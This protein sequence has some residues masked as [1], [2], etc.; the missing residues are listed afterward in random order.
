MGRQRTRRD[1]RQR[2]GSSIDPSCLDVYRRHG[3]TACK[4][5]PAIRQN[6]VAN[7]ASAQ[8]DSIPPLCLLSCALSTAKS[9]TSS[10]SF[11][12]RAAN[13]QR[14]NGDVCVL[15]AGLTAV[16]YGV[17]MALTKKIAID[18]AVSLLRS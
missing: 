14:R 4:A 16:G 3:P 1:P 12:G 10:A 2:A 8:D 18:N 6:G 17:L 13:A 9:R 5:Q 15:R 7:T 11:P